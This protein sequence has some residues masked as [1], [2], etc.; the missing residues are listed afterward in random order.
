MEKNELRKFMRAR[1]DA[2]SAEYRA[3]ADRAIL[4]ALFGLPE[5]R[6]ADVVFCYVGV[7]SEVDTLPLIERAF[8]DGKRVCAPALTRGGDMDA[9]EI[10]GVDD[11]A[12]TDFGLP[13]PKASC[14]KVPA[15][16][17]PFIVAPCICC[18]REGNRIGYGGGCYDRYLARSNAT[19]AVLCREANICED[20]GIVLL[21]HDAPADIVI[22]ERGVFRA[23]QD[24]RGRAAPEPD[25]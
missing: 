9:R 8:R 17:I 3:A 20:G 13:E 23:G 11:L 22:T 14:S 4:E 19:V 21:P 1:R 7:R 24:R 16:E 12:L 6:K 5:Y 25:T 10:T 2:L 15:D 18:D